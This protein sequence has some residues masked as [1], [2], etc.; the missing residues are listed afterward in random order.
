MNLKNPEQA[1]L[2]FVLANFEG[3]DSYFFHTDFL[4]VG[5]RRFMNFIEPKNRLDPTLG[6]KSMKQE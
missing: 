2:F 1:F 3:I 5:I 4:M 6:T